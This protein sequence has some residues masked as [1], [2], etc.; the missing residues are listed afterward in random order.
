MGNIY[1]G[2][3]WVKSEQKLIFN[4]VRPISTLE[5]KIAQIKMREGKKLPFKFSY[6]TQYTSNKADLTPYFQKWFELKQ[7]QNFTP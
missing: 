3:M 6:T 1:E 2:L 5:A 7:K 4:G